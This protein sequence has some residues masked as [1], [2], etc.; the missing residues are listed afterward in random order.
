ML[1]LRLNPGGSSWS[2]VEVNPLKVPDDVALIPECALTDQDARAIMQRGAAESIPAMV[3][4]LSTYRENARQ[5]NRSMRS[6]K[7]AL[8][9]RHPRDLVEETL[10]GS[11]FNG[12]KHPNIARAGPGN[13]VGNL[14]LL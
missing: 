7:C 11:D 10:K 3:V 14:L 4:D 13:A 12:K 9:A 5:K 2:L 6:E 8:A 1:G